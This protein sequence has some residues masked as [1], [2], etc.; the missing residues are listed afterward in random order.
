M[1][2][3]PIA[4]GARVTLCVGALGGGDYYVERLGD[5]GSYHVGPGALDPGVLHYEAVTVES[6]LALRPGLREV[7]ELSRGFLARVV[8]GNVV[9]V[10]N[11]LDEEVLTP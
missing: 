10:L 6:V 9:S 4:P 11:A 8:S 3:E 7:L 5:D 1:A 2:G